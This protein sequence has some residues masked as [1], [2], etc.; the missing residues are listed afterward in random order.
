VLDAEL[1]TPILNSGRANP[2]SA[3]SIESLA[4][5]GYTVDVTKAE[6]FSAVYHAPSRVSG[7]GTGIDLG[8]DVSSR[9]I[10]VVG[11]KG[12]FQKVPPTHRR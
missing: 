12:R 7:S 8:R 9:P 3:I 5:L 10:Y 4:D 1:M 11:P 6:A 2:L